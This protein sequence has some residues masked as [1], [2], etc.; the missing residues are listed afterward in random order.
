VG[1]L[2]VGAG[3]GEDVVEGALVDV[4]TSLAVVVVVVVLVLLGA[5]VV[6][7]LVVLGGLVVV[8]VGELAGA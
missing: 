8:V 4:A 2:L 7:A 1:E 6:G 3:F 5:V